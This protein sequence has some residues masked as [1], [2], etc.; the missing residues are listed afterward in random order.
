MSQRILVT[1]ALPYAN[2]SLHLGHL[3][4]Y[5]QADMY[6]RALKRLGSDALFICA[7]DAHGTPIEV[8]ARRQGITPES[9]VARYHAEHKTDFARFDVVFDHFSI[10]HSD[11]NRRI[12]EE[13]YAQLKKAEHVDE[14]EVDGNF[15]V[16]D[17]RFLPDRF[18]KGT[19]PRCGTADQYGDVCESCGATYAPTDLKS[20]YC[21]MCGNAPEVRKSRHVFFKLSAPEHV[22]FL[23]AWIDSGTLQTDVANYVRNWIDGGL[24]DWC[25]SRDGPYFGFAIPGLPDKYFYVWLDAPFG[26]VAA[27]A[28]WAQ[29]HDVPLATLWRSPETRVEH[30]IGKD[31]MYF[32]TLFWPAVLRATGYTLPSKVHVHGML[33]V[34]GEKMSKSRGTFINAAVFA[35][36]IE[37]QALRYYYACKY[38]AGSDDLDLS[39]DDFVQRV[40]TELVNKHANLFSRVTQFLTQK[41]EARL[42]DL[43]FTAAA[44]QA[45][46]VGDDTLVDAARRVVAHGRRIEALYRGRE[47]GQVIRELAF[48]ADIGN[49]Y[50]QAQKPWDQLKQDPEAARLTCTFVV[51]VC[52]ALAMYLWP[53]VPRM[54]EAGARSLG[55]TIDRMDAGLLFTERQRKIGSLERLFERLDRAVVEQV[56]TASQQAP[57]A[58][59]APVA[60]LATPLKAEVTYDDFQKLDLRVGRVVAAEPLPKSQ[61]LLRLQVDVGEATPRQIIAGLAQGYAPEALIGTQVV[62]VANLKPAKIMGQQSQGMVLAGEGTAQGLA[63]LRLDRELDSGSTVR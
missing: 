45:E 28:E 59:A 25:I 41:L 47:F 58:V 8:N 17:G 7:D 18:I 6:V 19:C 39:F 13:V 5:C 51:N 27:S 12:V 50:M 44:A 36:H 16:T 9:L 2:G 43:P 54:A 42:G 61:K 49:E 34:D 31:I 55:A 46:P 57:A 56:V 53:I 37:P 4:E 3:V 21:V 15:C 52:H 29:A 26:Y 30:V 35:E 40:N 11:A 62:V 60:S 48:I 20:P 24:R 33:T 23:R 14:R 63:V 22:D 38:S 10:T 1:A 32:H